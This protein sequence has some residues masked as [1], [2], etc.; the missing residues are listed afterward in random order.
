M[1]SRGRAAAWYLVDLAF[2]VLLLIAWLAFGTSDVAVLAV[3]AII[4]AGWIGLR[5]ALGRAKAGRAQA[6]V[7]VN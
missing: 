6:G 5:V 1:S 3:V 7:N 2:S 4:A